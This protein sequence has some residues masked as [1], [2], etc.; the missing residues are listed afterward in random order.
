M[1]SIKLHQLLSSVG[2]VPSIDL[3][4]PE[5][6]DISFNSKEVGEGTLF[7]GMPGLNVDGGKYC[8]EAIENGAEVAIIGSAAKN[9]VGSIDTKRVMVLDDNLDYIFGQ[10]VAEFWNRP[11]RK[12]TLI[13]VTGT[14]GKTTITFLLEY[15]LRKSGKKAA[16]FGTLFNRWP[17]FSE[18]SSHTTDFA[19]KLQKKLNAAVEADSE[20]AILEVSSHSI[21]QNRISGCEFDAAVFTN[22][23]QDHLDY[24]SDMESYFQTKRRLFF[25]PYLSENKGIAVLNCDD[26]WIC[27]LSSELQK[28]SSLVSTKK[29]KSKYRNEDFFYVTDKKFTGNGSSCIFHTS[30]EKINLFVPLVGEFNLMNAI[31]AIIILYKLN[32]S[33]KDLS[34]SIKSFPGAPG[35][36]EKIE[37]DNNQPKTFL[38][39]VII[40][41]AHTPDGLKNVLQSIRSLCQGKLITVFGCGGDRD[42]GKRPLMGSIAEEFSDLIFITS[43]NPRSEEPQKIVNDILMGT[44]KNNHIKIEIDRFKAIKKSIELAQNKDIVLIAGKGHE[45]YQILCDKVIDFDDRKIARELLE[46]KINQ[47]NRIM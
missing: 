36:M 44:K 23:S 1:R 5:I 6:N 38:P 16:L 40:D 42:K 33:L 35:R 7:L 9:N 19:D 31:Q 21:A 39:T 4:N 46:E 30:E 37:V 26:V 20:F 8:I 27:K 3:D 14:N 18:V 10:I 15:L 47:K 24:H 2:I 28:R 25:P 12:L 32:F 43:D 17:G 22:L 45:D 41:Y 11:S 29:I 34:R 13:G